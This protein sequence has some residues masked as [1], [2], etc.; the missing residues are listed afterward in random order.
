MFL[1]IKT[2]STET[3]EQL[4][5]E[6]FS[7]ST[8]AECY[9]FAQAAGAVYKKSRKRKNEKD[10]LIHDTASQNLG[11]YLEWR[12]LYGLDYD[13][14]AKDVDDSSIWELAVQKALFAEEAKK[15][16]TE[17]KRRSSNSKSLKINNDNNNKKKTVNYDSYIDNAV[18]E[19]EDD[20]GKEKANER[21]DTCGGNE[22]KK[23]NNN[24]SNKKTLPQFIFKRKDPN[25]G[26]VLLDKNGID[27]IHVLPARIDRFCVEKGTWAMAVAFYIDF[28]VDRN[29]NYSATILIDARAGEGWPNPKLIMVVSLIGQIISEIEKRHPGRCNT[30]IIFPIPRALTMIWGSIKGHFSPE[31]NEMMIVCSGPSD[32]KSPVP[33]NRLEKYVDGEIIDLLEKC[34]IGLFRPEKK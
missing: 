29:S 28:L 25:T 6:E 9:R 32:I 13:R 16:E 10:K 22:M 31:I 27:L 30:L 5:K 19:K 17:E 18:Q 26:K 11:E 24:H 1:V 15:R 23:N 3:I 4:L 20:E 12:A 8:D 2:M 7:D 34:R 14:P 21:S 33:K